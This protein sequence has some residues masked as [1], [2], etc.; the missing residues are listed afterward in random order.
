MEK[1]AE[2][3]LGNVFVMKDSITVF[4]SSRCFNSLDSFLVEGTAGLLVVDGVHG[5]IH[6]GGEVG[7]YA[8]FHGS[9]ESLGQFLKRIR[10]LEKSIVM[11]E[12]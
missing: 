2:P 1:K 4:S 11:I 9:P 3:P 5:K 6:E 12:N 10:L 8:V 7:G